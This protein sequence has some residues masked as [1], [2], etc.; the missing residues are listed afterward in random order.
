MEVYT[1]NQV[2]SLA[3]HHFQYLKIEEVDH[4]LTL[5]LNRAEKKNALSPTFLQEIAFALTYARYHNHIW[6]VI[7]KAEGN[8]FCAG[9]DLKAFAGKSDEQITSTIPQAQGEVLLGELFNQLHKPSIA[10]V[11]GPVYA[12]G[13]LIIAGVTYVLALEHVTFTLPEVKRGI[14]PMQ[15]MASL[16]NILPQ[17]VIIDLCLRAPTLSAKEAFSLGLVTHVCTEENLEKNLT[18]LT[19]EILANSPTAIRMGLEALDHLRN[20]PLQERHAYL[21][22]RLNLLLQSADAKE[23]LSAF[24]EKRK[25]IWT[26]E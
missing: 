11:Q 20:I 17:R 15:V 24:L 22:E 10:V 3:G 19:E 21:K 26:G 12:G 7:I 13:F 1:P 18:Q 2:A 23:G 8:V 6:L 9:A 25:P 5:T 14:W 4:I 16:M